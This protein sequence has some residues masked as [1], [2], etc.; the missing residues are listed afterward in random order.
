MRDR[1]C[2]VSLYSHEKQCSVRVTVLLS[3]L[4]LPCWVPCGHASLRTVPHS[5]KSLRHLLLPLHTAVSPTCP[6]TKY[7]IEALSNIP[8]TESNKGWTEEAGHYLQGLVFHQTISIFFCDPLRP[9]SFF[10]DPSLVEYC[11]LNWPSAIYLAPSLWNYVHLQGNVSSSLHNNHYNK[12]TS[13]S[14]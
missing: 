3:S 7:D 12:H 4:C 2:Q 1:I 11:S 10:L 13:T 6:C 5:Y 9:V 14:S 8:N